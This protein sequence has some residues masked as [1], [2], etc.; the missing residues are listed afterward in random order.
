MKRIY[1]AIAFIGG[2]LLVILT[3]FKKGEKLKAAEIKAE[4]EEV[5]REYERAGSE[6]MVAGLNKE[7]EVQNEV[8]NPDDSRNHFG[9]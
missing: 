3:A 7:K 9:S 8:I 5:A 4:T 1:A 2:I 6:A